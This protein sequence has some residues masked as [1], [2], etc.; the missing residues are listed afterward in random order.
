MEPIVTISGAVSVLERSDV[1]TDQILPKQFLKRMGRDGFG[2]FLFYEWSQQPGW[3][4]PVNPI[5]VAGSNFGCGS[6]REHAVWAL[7][8]YGF[9]AIV[10]PSFGDIF[11]FNCTKMGLL[12]VIL[13]EAQVEEI[14][15]A[16]EATIDLRD[17][18][19]AWDGGRAEFSID[20]RIQ[21][22]LLEGLDDIGTTL[23]VLDEVEAYE[24]A[25]TSHLPNTLELEQYS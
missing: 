6:S 22:N 18:S 4:L 16:G 19:V 21:S 23:K 3:S 11:Y 25:S 20:Q 7:H 9:R 17:R 13:P 10:A 15:R 24:Q 8:D 12:P 1:D 14:M 2:Q 5:L